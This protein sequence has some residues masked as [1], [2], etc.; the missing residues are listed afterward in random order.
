MSSTAE[1]GAAHAASRRAQRRP[2]LRT[3]YRWELRKLVSQKRTY[4]GLGLGCVLPLIFVASQLLRGDHPHD[5]GGI[6]ATEIFQSGLAT[7]VLMLT[8]ECVFFLP[9]IAT[10]VSGDIVAAEDGNGTLK[11]ILTRSVDRGQVLAA[12]ALAAF[13]YAATAVFLSA[14]VATVAGVASWGFHSVRTFTGTVV[15]AE[16]ALLLVFAA[17][18]CFL[19]PLAAV[20]A[21]GLLLSAVSRNSAASVVGTLG[22]TLVLA[23]VAQIPGLEGL[24]DYLLTTQYFAWQGLLRTPTDWAPVVHSAWVCALYAVPA[25]FAAYLVFLRRDVAGG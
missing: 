25:L 5:D 2:A 7:P 12:K 10:L 1:L 23:I 8:F 4:L 17:N 22:I 16:E 24:H 18:A 19:I 21:I 20:T 9:L 6:F 15:S 3:I 11:T 13:T 14:T